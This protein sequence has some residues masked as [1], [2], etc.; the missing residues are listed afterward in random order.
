MNIFGMS[1]NPGQ[2]LAG[3]LH[4][5][6]ALS[7]RF[8][9]SSWNAGFTWQQ[10]SVSLPSAFENAAFRLLAFPGCPYPSQYAASI[11]LLLFRS[12][13]PENARVKR[14]FKEPRPRLPNLSLKL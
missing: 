3:A 7:S 8:A 2:Q 6:D 11:L 1:L 12:A 14:A 13:L 9:T 5:L 4:F 10:Q